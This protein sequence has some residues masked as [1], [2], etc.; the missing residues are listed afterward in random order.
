MFFLFG[1][2]VR[3]IAEPIDDRQCAVCTTVQPFTR[4]TENLWFTMFSIPL[5]R[6]EERAHYLRCE[7][8]LSAYAED[9]PGEPSHISLTKQIVVYLLMGYRQEQ[10][11]K[12]ASEICLKVTGF[13][14]A[15]GEYQDIQRSFASRGDDMVELTRKA[16]PRLNSIGKQQ[17]L[18][19]AFLAS[20]VCCDLE[21]ED[22]L[23]INLI[24]NAL[25]VGLEFVEY[26][27]AQVRS[28]RNYD[29]RRL[30]NAESPVR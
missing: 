22:R 13:D 11:A 28:R 9:N 18:E 30:A 4:Q 5:L 26:A 29:V 1:E 2:R 16:S 10:H 21:Y 7:Q 25:D 6:I 17:L 12:L 19:A 23:R 27:I 3:S 24:G 14:Y 15:P 8:C 20:Y